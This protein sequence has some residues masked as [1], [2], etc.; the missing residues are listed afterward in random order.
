MAT[1]G[2]VG[3]HLDLSTRSV[4]SLIEDGVIARCASGEYDLEVCRLAYIRHLR[5][6]ASGRDDASPLSQARARQ[7]AASAKLKELQAAEVEGRMVMTDEVEASWS[8]V[9]ATMRTRVLAIPAESVPELLLCRTGA[10]MM[11]ILTR[12]CRG[13]LQEL[14]AA[15]VPPDAIEP[16]V[17]QWDG[18]TV[19]IGA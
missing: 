12:K 10:Q 6:K 2:D 13:A 5:G 9:A 3:R 4:T 17:P 16:P 11:A 14:S 15:V 8:R 7:A 18:G 19:W 1:I